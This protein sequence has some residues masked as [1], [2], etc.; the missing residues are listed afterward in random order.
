MKTDKPY[1]VVTKRNNEITGALPLYFFKSKF[2]NILTS[3]AF[4]T[5]SGILCSLKKDSEQK[6]IYEMLL[7]YSIS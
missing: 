2:G 6:Q 1:F 4:N 3:N 7:G 5:I